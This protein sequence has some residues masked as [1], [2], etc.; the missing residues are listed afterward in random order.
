VIIVLWNRVKLNINLPKFI[1]SSYS[2]KNALFDQ[3]DRV[4]R[5][6]NTIR[7]HQLSKKTIRPEI[8]LVDYVFSESGLSLI[9]QQVSIRLVYC[10]DTQRAITLTIHGDQVQR[11]SNFIRGASMAEA[12]EPKGTKGYIDKQYTVWC[13]SCCAWGRV[14]NPRKNE[15]IKIFCDRGWRNMKNSG[16]TCPGCVKK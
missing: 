8:G 10:I 1:T 4:I 15:A 6:L 5:K 9:T 3:W 16:W 13:G 12:I 11:F 2:Y 7:N 14:S